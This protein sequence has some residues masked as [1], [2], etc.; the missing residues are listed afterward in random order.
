VLIFRPIIAIHQLKAELHA[1][2]VIDVKHSNGSPADHREADENGTAPLKVAVPALA[3]RVEEPHDPVR[4][5]ISTAQVWPLVEV[6]A[7]AAPAAVLR[8]IGA[9]VLSCDDML[10]METRRRSSGIRKV[11]V[12]AAPTGPLAD[13]LAKGPFHEA[14]VDRFSKARALA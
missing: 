8:S 7:V 9:A 1:L 6:A 5:W 2:G 3:A 14:A 4:D 12:F 13:D 10:D 11:A